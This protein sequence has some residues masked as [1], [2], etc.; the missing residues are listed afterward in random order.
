MNLVCP[1]E[2]RS[3]AILRYRALLLR[4]CSDVREAR[5]GDKGAPVLRIVEEASSTTV[6][7]KLS[8]NNIALLLLGIDFLR[9]LMCSTSFR[10]FPRTSR[11]ANLSDLH[12]YLSA[13]AP[14]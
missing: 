7:G 1:R 11:R 8:L 3:A 13:I 5:K 12:S 6:S 2:F 4:W 10:Y 14:G 9:D